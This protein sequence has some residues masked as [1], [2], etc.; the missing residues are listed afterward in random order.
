MKFEKDFELLLF[1]LVDEAD[2]VNEE[3]LN[4]IADV[5]EIQAEFYEESAILLEEQAE[6]YET[7]NENFQQIEAEE[8]AE[9]ADTLLENQQTL[10]NELK[11]KINVSS[12]QKTNNDQIIQSQQ[13]LKQVA[14]TFQLATSTVK[15][16]NP[17]QPVG[18]ISSTITQQNSASEH[19]S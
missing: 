17:Q 11:Q 18:I 2:Q 8:N 13:S 10:L 9:R 3:L 12:V 1:Q 6:L 5:I 7:L 16:I 14:P 19:S 15:N 4:K